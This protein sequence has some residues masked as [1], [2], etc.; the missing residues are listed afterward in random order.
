MATEHDDVPF[1]ER[2]RTFRKRK[3]WTQA[4]LAARAHKSLETIKRLEQA[5]HT[6]PHLSTIKG[7]ADALELAEDERGLLLRAA[8]Y[9]PRATPDTQGGWGSLS[10]DV[11]NPDG[12]WLSWR[13]PRYQDPRGRIP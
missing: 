2:L 7:L 9:G 11:L 8:G 6:R 3:L 12:M 1:G 10:G 4:D 5:K 13:V